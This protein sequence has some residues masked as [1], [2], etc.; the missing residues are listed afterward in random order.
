MNHIAPH[1]GEEGNPLIIIHN[2]SG[3]VVTTWRCMCR[4]ARNNQAN[5]APFG[6]EWTSNSDAVIVQSLTLCIRTIHSWGVSVFVD[7]V[8]VFEWMMVYHAIECGGTKRN[9][10]CCCGWNDFAHSNTWWRRESWWTCAEIR[11]G[12]KVRFWRGN[13]DDIRE[14]PIHVGGL[15]M[16]T[17]INRRTEILRKSYG[18]SMF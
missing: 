2:G 7:A 15:A 6:R 4:C 11:W 10:M 1:T 14:A 18:R 16:I 9:A 12:I 8:S 13:D 3:H 17:Q 5:H